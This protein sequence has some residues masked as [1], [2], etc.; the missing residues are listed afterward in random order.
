MEYLADSQK[1]KCRTGGN[2]AMVQAI[3]AG[4]LA[5]IR[6]CQ[7]KFSNWRWNCSTLEGE[8]LFGKFVEECMSMTCFSN[9]YYIYIN[10]HYG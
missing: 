6:D 9:N 7:V 5:A 8:H 2:T 4:T 1:D 10:D 3:S